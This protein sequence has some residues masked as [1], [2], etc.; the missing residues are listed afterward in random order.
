MKIKFKTISLLCF[1]QMVL[2]CGLT[3]GKQGGKGES[4][5]RTEVEAVTDTEGWI[6]SSGKIN[7]QNICRLGTIGGNTPPELKA[8]VNK[9]AEDLSS[10]RLCRDWWDRGLD[11]KRQLCR[12]LNRC[13]PFE[14]SDRRAFPVRH[15]FIPLWGFDCFLRKSWHATTAQVGP[16]P[17]CRLSCI[18][19][20]KCT[21]HRGELPT[22]LMSVYQAFIPACSCFRNLPYRCQTAHFC[23]FPCDHN[24]YNDI[25]NLT[26]QLTV[27]TPPQKLFNIPFPRIFNLYKLPCLKPIRLVSNTARL[28]IRPLNRK[29]QIISILPLHW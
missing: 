1:G 20:T 15:S 4:R 13:V 3:C 18:S 7:P 14:L 27:T 23:D 9:L 22:S 24:I 25:I 11:V 2:F 28:H 6:T 5:K 26:R 12:F 16:Q 10:V 8:T 17:V 19:Y 29:S 21:D